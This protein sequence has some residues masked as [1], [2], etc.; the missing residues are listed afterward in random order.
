M[1]NLLEDVASGARNRRSFL[2]KLSLAGA[3]V[4]AG[5]P[6]L[7]GQSTTP[8]TTT[9]PT[10]TPPAITDVDILQ[11]ALNLEY[12]E[13]EFYT[14]A[15][16][17][18]GIDQQGVPITGSGT[19]GLTTGGVAAFIF[20]DPVQKLALELAANEQAHVKLIRG[21]ITAAGGTPIAKPAIN[22][23]ALGFGFSGERQFLLLARIFEEIGVTAYAGAA[24]LIVDKG[25][26]GTAARIL[27]T[28]AEH[29]GNIRVMI[30]QYGLLTTLLDGADTLAMP[31]GTQNF[32]VDANALVKLRTPGQVLFLAYGGAAGVKAGGFFPNGVNGNINTSTA[33]A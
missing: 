18:A 16:T 8:P 25:I 22:L 15:T 6:R 27:A 26:L 28:E 9:P 12:L 10:T 14:V 32:S 23:A 5:A 7:L 31:S 30:S 2:Q 19:G 24:P 29:V 20:A 33:S 17:G 3:A 11:F 13:A 1:N 21:A 4:A